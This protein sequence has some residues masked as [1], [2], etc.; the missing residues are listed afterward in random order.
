MH[1]ENLILKKD[2]LIELNIWNDELDEP[3]Y[4]IEEFDVNDINK[5]K[6]VSYLDKKI[7][8]DD[9]YTLR[10]YFK[11]FKNFDGLALLDGFIYDYLEYIDKCPI[12]NCI[13]DDIN[14]IELYK[15]CEVEKWEK[16]RIMD[17]YCSVHGINKNDKECEYYSLSFI[18]LEEL[19]DTPIKLIDGKCKIVTSYCDYSDD[20]KIENDMEIF[21]KNFNFKSHVTLYDFMKSIIWE[22]SFY[23]TPEET[24]EKSN[25]LKEIMDEVEDDIK[26]GK[27][28]EYEELKDFNLAEELVN[29]NKKEN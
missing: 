18:K 10:D 15:V 12:E 29:K 11:V 7:K 6:I 5:Y 16:D 20:N 25:E 21:N 4:I 24:E 8:I 28:N 14:Y 27:I 22:L 17:V 23:G 9:G 3:K 19:L 1:I 13:N 26:S 2:G